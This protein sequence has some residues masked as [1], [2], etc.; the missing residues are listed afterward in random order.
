MPVG[1][2]FQLVSCCINM[3]KVEEKIRKDTHLFKGVKVKFL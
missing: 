3:S 2:L 1:S